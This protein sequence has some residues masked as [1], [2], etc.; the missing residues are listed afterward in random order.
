MWRCCRGYGEIILG[1]IRMR[2][3]MVIF[4]SGMLNSLTF[5]LFLSLLAQYKIQ[6][7]LDKVYIHFYAFHVINCYCKVRKTSFFT[8]CSQMK[9]TRMQMGI[10]SLGMPSNG[11]VH[12]WNS[13]MNKQII[14]LSN[15]VDGQTE[16]ARHCKVHH[17]LYHMLPNSVCHSHSQSL[18]CQCQLVLFRG[19]I[20]TSVPN[21]LQAWQMW[22]TNAR[23]VWSH[24]KPSVST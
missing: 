4:M 18:S 19:Y 11:K 21:T 10:L 5:I 13:S 7:P 20:C 2:L 17:V 1:I 16:T 24:Q 15:P 6:Y 12:P 9:D 14:N 23:C 22:V 3:K 8:L